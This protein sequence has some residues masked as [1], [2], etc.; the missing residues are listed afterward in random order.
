[1][2]KEFISAIAFLSI[3][4]LIIASFCLEEK[5]SNHSVKESV[6]VMVFANEIK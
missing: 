3:A 6:Q 1:M 4:S 5:L 2:L